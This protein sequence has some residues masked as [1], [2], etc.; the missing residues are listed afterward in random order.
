MDMEEE[1]EGCVSVVQC[2]GVD[3]AAVGWETPDA[4]WH[5][6]EA[7]EGEVRGATMMPDG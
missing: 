3:D 5:M 1:D 7:D 6:E 2:K 4:S